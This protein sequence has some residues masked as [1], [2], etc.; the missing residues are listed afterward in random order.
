MLI[1][2]LTAALLVTGGLALAACGG[3]DPDPSADRNSNARQEREAAL[4]YARCMRGQ[5]I[6]MPDP[7]FGED[8]TIMQPGPEEAVDSDEMEAARRACRRYRPGGGRAPS[9]GEREEQR[10]MLER[11]VAYAECMR[12]EGIDIPDPQTDED[13]KNLISGGAELDRDDPDFSEAVETCRSKVSGLPAAL[14][15]ARPGPQRRRGDGGQNG[16][17]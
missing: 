16:A 12:E 3:D 15:G 7:Q 4:T 10:E 17:P 2:S 9:E 11:A 5:G 1:R 13:G 14:P 6:G 8:G